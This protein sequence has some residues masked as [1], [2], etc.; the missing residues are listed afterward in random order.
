M[1]GVI[2]KFFLIFL[3][4]LITFVLSLFS[5]ALATSS[6]I[7][8]SRLLE[9]RDRKVREKIIDL[10]EEL[11]IAVEVW[12]TIF[13]SAFL[14]S[15][16][17][18]FPRLRLWTIW[19]LLFSLALVVFGFEFLPRL[20]YSFKRKAVFLLLIPLAG[21]LVF[22]GRPAVSFFKKEEEAI[23]EREATDEEIQTFIEEA[24]EEGIIEREEGSLL[25]SVVEFGDTLV[26]EIMTPRVDMI[27]IRKDASLAELRELISKEKYSRI[28]VYRDRID[29]I[30]G[31]A[32]VKDLL[33]Y[34][35]EQ[36][37]STPVEK[38]MRPVY[39]VP[40]SMK[41][42]ELL[43]EFQKRKQKM[44]IVVDEH[45]GIAGLV[46]MK[47]I[48]EEIV[49]E[50]RDEYDMEEEKIVA[51]SSDEYLVSGDTEVEELEP[52]LAEDLSDEEYLTVGGLVAHHLGRLP[53]KGE[54]FSLKNLRFEILD[55]DQKK[56]I[57]VKIKKEKQQ[58]K[59]RE[60]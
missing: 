11:R 27:C 46:T 31:L 16:F 43:K 40:E 15:L 20:L 5:T 13:L 36:A 4:F 10:K 37:K 7:S 41:V 50:I 24:R 58:D 14:L 8:L 52:I 54:V 18:Y 6:R 39:F 44:A 56:I 29:N 22:L 59:E 34:S 19:A 2:F 51:L 53:A 33:A 1:S 21:F 17:Y 3:L 28:P 45:G 23:P 42:K 30:E 55:A 9:D 26:R 35:D 49:G 57:R 32:I 47:D 60:G 25:R 12:R 48:V 38:I